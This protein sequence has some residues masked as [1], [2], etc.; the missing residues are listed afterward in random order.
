MDWQT[1][2][3]SV[4]ASSAIT[5]GICYM[6]KKSFDHALDLQFQKFK[7]QNKAII[8]E[9]FRRSAF[10]YDK[11]FES[12][13]LLLS[14]IYRLRNIVRDLPEHLD[15][16][17]EKEMERALKGLTTFGNAL[18]ELLYE[19]RATLPD[20]VFDIAHPM[21]LFVTS[22]Y[23]DIKLLRRSSTDSS[24]ANIKAVMEVKKSIRNSFGHIDKIYSALT[25]EVKR[26]LGTSEDSLSV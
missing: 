8:Q 11:Q 20:F 16:G 10:L 13:K 18:E 26:R 5:A 23:G 7:E 21:K 14:L 22:V 17:K 15:S 1:I 9:N 12:L 25:D 2:V 6:L 24:K 4:T 19:E 3:T